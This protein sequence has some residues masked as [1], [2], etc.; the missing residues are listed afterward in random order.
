MRF[1]GASPDGVAP[2]RVFVAAVTGD[3]IAR[4]PAAGIHRVG[5]YTGLTVAVTVS[6]GIEQCVGVQNR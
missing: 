6:C 5:G 3:H 2:L 1:G 4:V